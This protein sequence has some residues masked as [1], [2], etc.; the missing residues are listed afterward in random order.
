MRH[1][2][3]GHIA[4]LLLLSSA[5]LPAPLV[6][7]TAEDTLWGVPPHGALAESSA[8]L[9]AGGAVGSGPSLT[10]AATPQQSTP[11]PE[12]SNSNFAAAG[13]EVLLDEVLSWARAYAQGEDWADV[14]PRTWARNF[15]DGW[16]WDHDSF[17]TNN[18]AHPYNGALFYNSAR[19]NGFGFWGSGGWTFGASVLWE[20]LGENEA[21]AINDQV[22][23]TL[24]GMAYGEVTWQLSALVLRNNATGFD[25]VWRE[26]VDALLNP[27]RELH[28]VLHGEAW[29]VSSTPVAPQGG[30]IKVR[31]DIGAARDAVDPVGAGTAKA[32]EDRPIFAL[33]AVGGDPFD[34]RLR[35]PFS[36]FELGLEMSPGSSPMW[37]AVMVRGLLAPLARGQSSRGARL[38]G[39]TLNSEYT[40]IP[41]YN[42]ADQNLSLDFL[43]RTSTGK[44]W[45][46]RTDLGLS[47][48]LL[49]STSS[50]YAFQ[51]VERPY[52]FGP[53]LGARVAARL[54]HRGSS[55]LSLGYRTYW[56]HTVNGAPSDH[57]LDFAGA[58]VRLP[59]VGG[60][61]G[62]VG[63]DLYWRRSS[64]QDYG[65][66]QRSSR[67][68]RVSVGLGAS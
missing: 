2:Y 31:F 34:P 66:V 7:Q 12:D 65:T 3:P 62:G 33:A 64:Y 55:I 54:E 13:A 63:Y 61:H 50:E 41:A 29:Q 10:P 57:R 30:K 26:A 25:R 8:V 28:R 39:I 32:Y 49:G 14:S 46:V 58:E 11:R 21:P 43:T 51:E 22:N 4:L 1:A 18:F 24:G 38:L 36:S 48:V 53:G 56:L 27:G 68:I 60:L 45:G 44:G 15:Q 5:R 37:S 17:V 16:H 6:A 9:Q 40:A 20:Y 19:S 59:L 42:F 47:A 67:Q 35:G 52:D 23:T